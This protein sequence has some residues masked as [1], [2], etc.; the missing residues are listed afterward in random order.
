DTSPVRE[1][2]DPIW[3]DG[4]VYFEVSDR[5]SVH[6]YRAASGGEPELVIGGQRAVTGLSVAGGRVAF[7]STS[8]DDPTSLRV[9]GLDGT[10]E[11]VLFDP[12]QWMGEVALGAVRSFNFSHDG[13]DI[14][15][16]RLL[17]PGATGA[18]RLPTLLYIHGGPHA[19][20]GWRFPFVLQILAGGGNAVVFC[21]PPGSQSYGE[22]FATSVLGAWGEIDFP[23][24]MAL[25]DRAVEDGFADPERLGVGG[26][27]YGGFSTLWAITHT[28]RFKAAVSA[29]PVAAMRGFYGSARI[30]WDFGTAGMGAR[31][32]AGPPPFHPLSPLPSPA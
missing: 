22:E 28:D 5:G 21:N 26:A 27:S 14:D 2:T 9:A 18:E 12:N 17:P 19:A 16:W 20:Y 29:R 10:G 6:V 3:L 15:A 32:W 8:F 4:R 1:A 24:F 30:R 7:I 13:R 25:L 11:R 23:Y 31:P